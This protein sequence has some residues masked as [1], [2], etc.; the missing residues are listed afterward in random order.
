MLEKMAEFFDSRIEEYEEH[1]MNAIRSAAEFY[2]FT[3]SLLPQGIH[4]GSGMRNRI[5]VG[6]LLQAKPECR[7]DR[8]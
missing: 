4:S 7:C 1:Q 2:P 8:H 5:G 6:L 3:A